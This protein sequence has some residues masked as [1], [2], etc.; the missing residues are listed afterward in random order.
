MGEEHET[1]SYLSSLMGL[2]TRCWSKLIAYRYTRRKDNLP[3]HERDLCWIVIQPGGGLLTYVY[4][5]SMSHGG[6]SLG[7]YFLYKS[8]WVVT[9]TLIK[10]SHAFAEVYCEADHSGG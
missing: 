6:V 2:L 4:S 3:R 5:S 10:C 8:A 7:S 9:E 1:K